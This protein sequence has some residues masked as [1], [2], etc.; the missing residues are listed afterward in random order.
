MVINILNFFAE[1]KILLIGATTTIAELLI[2][3]INTIRRIRKN[4]ERELDV[5]ATMASIG[6]TCKRSKI[7]TVLWVCNPISLFRAAG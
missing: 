5:K 7:S 2:I 1:N 3:V 4:E 6:H